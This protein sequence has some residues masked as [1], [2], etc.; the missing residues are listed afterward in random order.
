MLIPEIYTALMQKVCDGLES[1]VSID[2][3]E[4]LN[5]FNQLKVQLF[6]NLNVT[7]DTEYSDDVLKDPNNIKFINTQS[8]FIHPTSITAFNSNQLYRYYG[9]NGDDG[10]DILKLLN[11]RVAD[12]EI[13]SDDANKIIS[14]LRLIA[15]R[16]GILKAQL[17][18]TTQENED[19]INEFD[20]LI[21][22][23][24][25]ELALNEPSELQDKS[26]ILYNIT[27]LSKLISDLNTDSSALL[28]HRDNL[29]DKPYKELTVDT[30]SQSV[31]FNN[32]LSNVITFINTNALDKFFEFTPGYLSGIFKQL[33]SAIMKFNKNKKKSTSAI[34]FPIKAVQDSVEILYSLKQQAQDIANNKKTYEKEHP[35]KEPSNVLSNYRTYIGHFFDE[36]DRTCKS[37]N[38]RDIK[39]AI[40]LIKGSDN[41]TKHPK[42]IFNQI[43]D[44]AKKCNKEARESFLSDQKPEALTSIKDKIAPIFTTISDA[45]GRSCKLYMW[46]NLRTGTTNSDLWESISYLNRPNDTDNLYPTRFHGLRRPVELYNMIIEELIKNEQ[47]YPDADIDRDE[48]QALCVNQHHILVRN[49]NEYSDIILEVKNLKLDNELTDIFKAFI[50]DVYLPSIHWAGSMDPDSEEVKKHIDKV[51]AAIEP[52]LNSCVDKWGRIN[53]LLVALQGFDQYPQGLS[54]YFQAIYDQ[55]ANEK[56]QIAEYIKENNITNINANEVNVFD[57]VAIDNVAAVITDVITLANTFLDSIP[58]AK[59]GNKYD[60]KQDKYKLC[61]GF[62]YNPTPKSAQEKL[63]NFC[64]V[65]KGKMTNGVQRGLTVEELIRMFEDWAFAMNGQK[66]YNP[67]Q[68]FFNKNYKYLPQWVIKRDNAVSNDDVRKKPEE[69]LYSEIDE[70][71]VPNEDDE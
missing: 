51:R 1:Y 2:T 67:N 39:Y 12:K 15:A 20:K 28:K 44:W 26:V 57:S 70:L 40:K 35:G 38:A 54:N 69:K 59:F 50:K 6:E 48:K 30:S 68:A 22:L 4:T 55:I 24:A 63:K 32:T 7:S 23:R 8:T 19:R 31:I 65:T 33:Q 36:L 11:E 64:K 58:L 56:Q 13:T 18:R 5:L 9:K 52:Y 41:F 3:D 29:F 45:Q 66:V 17:I 16:M 47:K 25:R 21:F 14:N 49:R 43:Q 10:T 61:W 60:L 53:P 71:K 62:G 42:N 37:D 46:K 34:T 27:N